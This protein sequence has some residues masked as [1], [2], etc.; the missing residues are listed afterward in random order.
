MVGAGGQV[1]AGDV[2]MPNGKT[3]AQVLEGLE[4]ELASV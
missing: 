4:Q 2:I 1:Q 3:L